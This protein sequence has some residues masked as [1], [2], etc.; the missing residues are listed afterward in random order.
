MNRPEPPSRHLVTM[1]FVGRLAN[2]KHDQPPQNMSQ[3]SIKYDVCLV[4]F[5]TFLLFV[6]V[7]SNET[8]CPKYV[9]ERT[10]KEKPPTDRCH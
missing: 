5:S 9:S 2:R 8:S 4:S 10:I 3:N 1:F 7:S 6:G